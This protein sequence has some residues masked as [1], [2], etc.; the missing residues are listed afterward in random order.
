MKS[1]FVEKD[2]IARAKF[3][4]VSGSLDELNKSPIVSKNFLS[5]CCC[6][7]PIL[8]IEFDSFVDLFDTLF[9]IFVIKI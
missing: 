5:I 8:L 1:R 6:E 2:A 4:V 7:I 3:F 9:F